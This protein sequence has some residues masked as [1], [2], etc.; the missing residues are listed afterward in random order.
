MKKLIVITGG[1]RSGKSAFAEKLARESDAPV[2]YIAT[3]I[4]FDVEMQDRIA[5]HRK[6][7]PASWDTWEGYRNLTAVFDNSARTYRVILLDCITILVSNW[8]LEHSKATADQFDAAAMERLERRI[9]ADLQGFLDAAARHGVT[10]L[11][12]TNEVGYGIVPENQLAR[13]FRDIAGRINQAIAAR[14]DE[15]YLIVC[16]LPLKIK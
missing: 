3:A 7:R 1:A 6:R 11:L 16:G 13:I 5:H 14:A 9:W 15:V 2:L 10:V 12:V 8:L 4:P